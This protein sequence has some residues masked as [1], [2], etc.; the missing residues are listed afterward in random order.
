MLFELD[1]VSVIIQRSYNKG[2]K[3]S[4]LEGFYTKKTFGKAKRVKR[5]NAQH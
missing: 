5:N 2:L 1:I 4:D 3:L